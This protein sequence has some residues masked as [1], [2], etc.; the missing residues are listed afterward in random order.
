MGVF[1]FEKF[2]R[3]TSAIAQAIAEAT[4]AGAFSLGGVEILWQLLI[5][6]SCR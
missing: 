2:A 5:K 1:E 6:I 3:G 4:A